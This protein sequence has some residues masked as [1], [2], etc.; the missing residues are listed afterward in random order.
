MRK[1]RAG[2]GCKRNLA[3]GFPQEIVGLRYFYFSK[4]ILLKIA[5]TGRTRNVRLQAC[6]TDCFLGLGL[7]RSQR[8]PKF[9]ALAF[10]L[11]VLAGDQLGLIA[12]SARQS[13]SVKPTTP[14]HFSGSL[15][16]SF[17]RFR[18]LSN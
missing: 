6:H 5:R 4:D 8:G 7:G 13:S 18:T 10:M 15:R 1:G 17:M 2:H 9:D 16:P 14:A 3:S 12:S 11:H